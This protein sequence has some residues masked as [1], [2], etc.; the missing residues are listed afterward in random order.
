MTT[1]PFD[2]RPDSELGHLLREHLG[3]GDPAAFGARLRAAVAGAQP[4][5]PWDVLSGWAMPGLAA[6]AILM[7]TLGALL[8]RGAD[9]RGAIEQALEL[10]SA[11]AELVAAAYSPSPDVVLGAALEDR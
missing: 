11:P 8:S 2:P 9:S 6:A 7:L 5:S 10:T 4:P 1:D 3:G